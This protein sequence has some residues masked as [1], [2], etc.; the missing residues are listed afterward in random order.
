MATAGPKGTPD[1]PQHT[2]QHV[3]SV[4]AM[5]GD[6]GP[7]AVVAGLVA[8]AQKNPD[9]RFILHGPEP[10]LDRLVRRNRIL[11]GRGDPIDRAGPLAWE[12]HVP[13]D[14]KPIPPLERQ[15][16]HKPMSTGIRAID[17]LLTCGCGQRLGIFAGSGGAYVFDNTFDPGFDGCWIGCTVACSHGVKDFIPFTGPYKGQ[18]VFVDGPE[19]ETIAGC[20]SNIGV[21]DPFTIVEM[22]F[23]CDAYGLDTISVGT[24]IA[25]VMECFEMGLINHAVPADQLDAKTDEIVGR[26]ANGAKWAIR[27]TKTA[28]NLPLRE[29]AN[30]FDKEG[31]QVL[32]ST[33]TSY[34]ESSL[35]RALQNLENRT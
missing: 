31:A 5:G 19:Y 33:G 29:L 20:G 11:D 8:F 35:Q 1:A 4:D 24:S 10:Q 7:A 26:L 23:Y 32:H 25:F 21:F 3:I 18:K 28:I 14:G 15:R 16:I 6:L 17:A 13:L 2:G 30:H 22:N 12:A 34:V 27:W 9:I